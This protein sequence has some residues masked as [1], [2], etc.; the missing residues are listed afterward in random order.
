MVQWLNAKQIASFSLAMVKG[1][2]QSAKL[3]LDFSL[4]VGVYNIQIAVLPLSS[5]I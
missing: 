4:G 5:E 2:L 1:S 3:G